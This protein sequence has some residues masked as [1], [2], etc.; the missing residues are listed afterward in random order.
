MQEFLAV[1][2]R[3]AVAQILVV[4]L[5]LAVQ[6]PHLAVLQHPH[7]VVHKL[8]HLAVAKLKLQHLAVAK[9]KLLV[10]HKLILAALQSAWV[11]LPSVALGEPQRTAVLSLHLVVHLQLLQLHAVALLQWFKLHQ[12]E[13]PDCSHATDLLTVN[14][15]G[16]FA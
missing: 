5:H 16:K 12:H 6:P 1:V 11:S 9:L 15:N 4:S 14:A 2:R 13:Q 8:Q 7:L 10:V 3:R